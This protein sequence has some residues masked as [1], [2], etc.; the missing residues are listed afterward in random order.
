MGSALSGLLC[1]V[2]GLSPFVIIWMVL[3]T[4]KERD[5]E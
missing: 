5:S 4:A 1:L 3:A 2:W